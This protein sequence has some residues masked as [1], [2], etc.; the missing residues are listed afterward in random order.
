MQHITADPLSFAFDGGRRFLV[1]GEFHYFRVPRCDWKKRLQLFRQAGGNCVATYVP[2]LLHEPTEG[3]FQFADEQA[4]LCGFLDECKEAGLAVLC[5]PGPYQYSELRYDGLPKWLFDEYLQIQ[6]LGRDGRPLRQ[7][8]ASY[9]HPLFLQKV[10]AWYDAVLPILARYQ[11]SVGGPVS[12]LQVDNELMGI[13]EWFGDWDFHPVT[14]GFGREDGRFPRFLTS[15]YES[16]GT[17]NEAWGTEFI[18]FAEVEPPRARSPLKI[19]ER[20]RE[21]DYQDFYFETV[22]EYAALLVGWMREA[23]LRC[24]IVHN[25]GSPYMNSFFLETSRRLG[26]DFLLGS[27]HYYNLDL[28]WDQNNPTPRYAA[29]VFYSLEMLR[30]MGY[31]PSVLELPAGSAA[32]W[33]PI[34]AEDLR[35]CYLTNLAFGMKG[36]NYYIFT[37]GPNPPE[38]GANG[39]SYDYG[40]PVAADGT[41][42]ETFQT[43]EDFG[44]ILEKHAW[45]C[46]AEA[47]ADYQLG[48]VWE[49]TRSAKYDGPDAARPFTSVAAWN[50]FR[51]GIFFSSMGAGF[52]P[53]MVDIENHTPSLDLPLWVAT[54]DG[55]DE[56]AQ[57]ALVE[58]VRNGGHLIFGPVVPLTDTKYRS[59]RILMDYLGTLPATPFNGMFPDLHLGAQ[60]NIP[61]NGGLWTMETCPHGAEIIAREDHS[62]ATVGWRVR[63]EKGTA[64]WLGVSWK[65]TKFAHSVMVAT[66]LGA[67]GRSRPTVALDNPNLWAVSRSQGEKRAVFVLNLFSSSQQTSVHVA[68]ADGSTEFWGMHV[69]APMEVKILFSPPSSQP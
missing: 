19:G 25:S 38:A 68:T 52:C 32:D 48:L 46:E 10:K 64:T 62:G 27:D 28:D 24:P 1:S 45:L 54:S 69:L 42:R 51:K 9:L 65:H 13:H 18:R 67:A 53:R 30:E 12:L 31:P 21:R 11:V 34:T 49:H 3:V 5:R 43:L 57:L 37:G 61:A 56:K 23:G 39:N 66:L 17:L 20:R 41:K 26:A 2:W 40:A 58:F 15:R 6:A 29:K 22:A 47:D 60:R 4:D 59:C 7:S 63:R 16:V 36:L 50:L 44:A 33:P 55:L 35:A 8:S 14:M